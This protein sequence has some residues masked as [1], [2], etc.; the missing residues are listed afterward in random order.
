LSA[1]IYDFLREVSVL[2]KRCPGHFQAF[3]FQGLDN[4][5]LMESANIDFVIK[6]SCFWVA[7]MV[8]KLL[9]PGTILVGYSLDHELSGTVTLASCHRLGVVGLLY[10]NSEH[11]YCGMVLSWCLTEGCRCCENCP[12]LGLMGFRVMVVNRKSAWWDIYY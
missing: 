8:K 11:I 12:G 1:P 7:E 3:V 9:S 2:C 5:N 6:E 10:E 4:F